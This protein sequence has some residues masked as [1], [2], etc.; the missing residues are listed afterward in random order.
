MLN[1]L[2]GSTQGRHTTERCFGHGWLSVHGTS[3][4]CRISCRYPTG[5]VDGWISQP[6][7]SREMEKVAGLASTRGGKWGRWRGDISHR[8]RTDSSLGKWVAEVKWH[9]IETHSMAVRANQER[10]RLR[11]ASPL[12]LHTSFGQE[13]RFRIHHCTSKD[14]FQRCSK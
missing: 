1:D 8:Q 14:T 11:R 2:P 4:S 7:R 10:Y 5:N 12:L 13:P 6:P 9:L 3:D